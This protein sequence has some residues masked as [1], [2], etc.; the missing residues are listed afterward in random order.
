MRPA[1]AGRFLLDRGAGAQRVSAG[2]RWRCRSS[3]R[4]PDYFANVISELLFW[5]GEDRLLFGSD[6]AIWTPQW[7]VEKFVAYEL[8]EQIVKDK[9]VNLTLEAKKKILG[10]NA[11]K[12]YDIDVAAQSRKL[13]TPEL[14]AAE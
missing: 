8:P 13:R 10:L 9:G 12:L 7:L 1:A 6:Y 14:V 3:I 11:A 5:L 4:G 2:W